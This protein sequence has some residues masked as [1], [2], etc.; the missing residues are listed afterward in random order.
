MDEVHTPPRSASPDV[1]KAPTP[2]PHGLRGVPVA[3]RAHRRWCKTCIVVGAILAAIAS[4]A[5][6][7]ASA[8][9]WRASLSETLPWRIADGTALEDTRSRF[10]DWEVAVRD[11]GW[12]VGTA[13]SQQTASASPDDDVT[14][15][16]DN[17]TADDPID[18]AASPAPLA[19]ET[20]D[21]VAGSPDVA[22]PNVVVVERLRPRI[23]PRVP[24]DTIADA[25]PLPAQLAFDLAPWRVRG[26][27]SLSDID[28]TR[29]LRAPLVSA[30]PSVGTGIVT[31]IIHGGVPYMLASEIPVMLSQYGVGSK[32]KLKDFHFMLHSLCRAY[33][34]RIPDVIFL[35]NVHPWPLLTAAASPANRRGQGPKADPS[36]F[37]ARR[38]EGLTLPDFDAMYAAPAVAAPADVAPV[39]SLC[40]MAGDLDVLYPNMYFQ[41]PR[42]WSR[43]AGSIRRAGEASAWERRR[44]T[45]WWRGASGWQWPAAAPRALTVARYDSARWSDFAFTSN[46]PP[47]LQ[48]WARSPW[49]RD[50]GGRRARGIRSGWQTRTPMEIV[51]RYKYALHLP[52]SYGATYSRTLQFLVW[53]G[54]TVFLYDCPY[55]EYYY[56]GLRPW[57]HYIPVNLTNLESRFKW[58]EHHQTRA[59]DIASASVAFANSHL[60][61]DLVF[62]YWVQLLREYASLQT[63]RVTL[64]EGA[65]TCWPIRNR[66]VKPAYIPRRARR[67]SSAICDFSD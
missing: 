36:A 40:K 41:S 19:A 14:E 48:S 13:P 29:S 45:M 16:L 67:C 4:L 66:A 47:I 59:R 54:V 49:Y 35:W 18:A 25:S 20:S 65:C 38:G 37:A 10:S 44:G 33:P 61:A 26:G 9:R 28:M 32:G 27:I 42:F 22:S 50:L 64:P 57:E 51:A 39:L 15:K 12:G 58:A 60:T 24:A 1:V 5:V 53:T 63:F 11:D 30:Q 17:T 3:E 46:W 2:S 6:G 55:F 62:G 56:G 52:G 31:A 23:Q 34:G 7:L 43:A 21:E 8:S